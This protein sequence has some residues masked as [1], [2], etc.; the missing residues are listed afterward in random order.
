MSLLRQA[1]DMQQVGAHRRRS[2]HRWVGRRMCFDSE[3]TPSGYDTL[4]VCRFV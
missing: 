1:D 4:F 2:Q 3:R